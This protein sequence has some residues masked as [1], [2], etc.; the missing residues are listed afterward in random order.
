MRRDL[1]AVLNLLLLTALAAVGAAW[2]A[3][4][5]GGLGRRENAQPASCPLP[6][7]ETL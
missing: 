6:A 2:L 4:A 1:Q 7:L 5:G 3:G